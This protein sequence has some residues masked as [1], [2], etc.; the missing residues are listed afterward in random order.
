MK[1][2]KYIVFHRV[3]GSIKLEQLSIMLDS[4]QEAADFIDVMKEGRY[5]KTMHPE[6]ELFYSPIERILS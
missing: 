1:K 5:Y 6:Y 4:E 2:R 3:P